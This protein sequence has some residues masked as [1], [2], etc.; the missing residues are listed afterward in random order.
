MRKLFE[1]SSEEKQRILEMH[2]SATKRNYL[3]EQVV[4]PTTQTTSQ[5]TGT[6][7]TT[8]QTTTQS[9]DLS[10]LGIKDVAGVKTIEVSQ[11][12]KED[13][14]K[15]ANQTGEKLFGRGKYDIIP[16]YGEYNGC[17]LVV[18]KDAYD[19]LISEKGNVTVTETQ[20]C[21]NPRFEGGKWVFSVKNNNS[22]GVEDGKTPFKN[23]TRDLELRVLNQILNG[24]NTPGCTNQDRHISDKYKD[25][26]SGGNWFDK[27]LQQAS[28]NF[29]N[30]PESNFSALCNYLKPTSYYRINGFP[31]VKGRCAVTD[32]EREGGVLINVDEMLS[33]NEFVRIQPK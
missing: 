6:T 17:L 28:I 19:K 10:S 33:K 29:F 27:G 26:Y 16:E 23:E 7:Q 30:N 3:S 9:S 25:D 5:P 4:Q 15:I 12:R 21:A 14:G 24:R 31:G 1:I 8:T 20:S 13:M 18:K 11:K 32:K 22:A 2:E